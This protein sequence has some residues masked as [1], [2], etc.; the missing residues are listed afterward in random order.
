MINLAQSPETAE[1]SIP[2]LSI[3]VPSGFSAPITDPMPSQNYHN[4]PMSAP[5]RWAH[6]SPGHPLLRQISDSRI[7]GLK[8][9]DNSI[10]EGRPS[11][12]LSNCSNDLMA[13]GSQ[14]G[15]SDGW[16]MRTFSEMVAS[17]QKG[18]WSF[19]SEYLGSGH[20]KLSGTSSRFSYSPSMDLQACMGCGKLLTERSAWSSAGNNVSVVSVL[21]CGHVFHA[22]CLETMTAKEDSYDPV[23]LVCTAGE[24]NLLKLSKKGL[25]ADSEIKAKNYK[26]S[27]NRVVDSY[28]DGGLDVFDRQNDRSRMEAGSS[29]GSSFG[30]P[31]L[32]RRFSLG[33]KWSRSLS[34]NDSARKKGFWARYRKD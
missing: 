21:A 6:R 30:K 23:C 18:R 29:T 28:L 17:S 2:N 15:S 27:R 4:L 7:L 20:H 12:V 1:F 9:P 5:S 16:S 31:F 3:S 24:K 8:S 32:K 33:S 26:I 19:D 25:R 22:E 14:F 11:F 13:T 34:E 10:S